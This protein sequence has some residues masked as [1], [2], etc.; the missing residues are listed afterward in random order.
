MGFAMWCIF[1]TILM[2]D[3]SNIFSSVLLCSVITNV[4]IFC[5]FYMAAFST[6]LCIVQI[7]SSIFPMCIFFHFLVCVFSIIYCA[8]PL[9]FWHLM[10]WYFPFCHLPCCAFS[11]QF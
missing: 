3:Y 9:P 11:I 7:C 4:Y 2:C 6:N 1:Y 5:H 10:I 8:V